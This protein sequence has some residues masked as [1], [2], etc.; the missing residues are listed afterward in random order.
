MCHP[1][2]PHL[3]SLQVVTAVVSAALVL[4]VEAA[5]EQAVAVVDAATARAGP[6]APSAADKN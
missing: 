2:S 6:A 4:V 5:V 1:V 3:V